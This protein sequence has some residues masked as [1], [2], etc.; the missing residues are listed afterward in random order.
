MSLNKNINKEKTKE[1]LYQ[2]LR[3]ILENKKNYD[4][5]IFVTR[6]SF[7]LL[8]AYKKTNNVNTTAKLCSSKAINIIGRNFKDKKIL[9]IDDIL[10]HGKALYSLKKY[11]TECYSPAVVDLSVFIQKYDQ[12]DAAN[13][14]FELNCQNKYLSYE[15]EWKR[16]TEYL[17]EIF[18]DENVPYTSYVLDMDIEDIDDKDVSSLVCNFQAEEIQHRD[19]SFNFFVAFDDDAKENIKNI[20]Q[21][22]V[23]RIYYSE[24]LKKITLSPY[25]QLNDINN[26]GVS[27]MWN[28]L[29]DK[30]NTL[31]L[32]CRS[33]SDVEIVRALTACLS[34]AVWEDSIKNNLSVSGLN[35]RLVCNFDELDYSFYDGFSDDL[36]K[37]VKEKNI[38]YSLLSDLK[39]QRIYELSDNTYQSILE[40]DNNWKLNNAS[41]EENFSRYIEYINDYKETQFEKALNEPLYKST[42]E[43]LSFDYDGIPYSMLY[44]KFYVENNKKIF[45]LK[46]IELLELG[47]ISADVQYHNSIIYTG[48][49]TGERSWKLVI[50]NNLDIIIPIAYIYRTSEMYSRLEKFNLENRHKY[51]KKIIDGLYDEF[52]LDKDK[53]YLLINIFEKNMPY[54]IDSI[55]GYVNENEQNTALNEDIQKYVEKKTDE[56]IEE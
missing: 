23:L 29:N 39:V 49:R 14:V 24:K 19:L 44:S 48:I 55:V 20:I 10:I 7:D 12:Y 21:L 52:N 53:M 33:L 1:L 31:S 36:K 43:Y 26:N 34:V 28:N 32:K 38:F 22:S 25:V 3:E 37:I 27:D 35:E 15:S 16:V 4:Y 9:I 56:Y 18:H 6:K 17:V 50:D 40:N 8:K 54:S 46:Y 11:I 41:F 45:I 42:E 47:H 13:T 51:F 30:I 2:Y 5:I